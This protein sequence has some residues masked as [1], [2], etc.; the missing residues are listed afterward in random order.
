MNIDFVENCPNR[1]QGDEERAQHKNQKNAGI[2]SKPYL[3]IYGR[4]QL[5]K[6]KSYTLVKRKTQ[7]VIFSFPYNMTFFTFL[8]KKPFF[9]QNDF[10]FFFC[11]IRA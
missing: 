9:L 2:E 1:V 7:K 8:E 5:P 3:S 11:I 4:F 6:T 10:S